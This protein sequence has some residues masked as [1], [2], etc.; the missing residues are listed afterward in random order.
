MYMPVGL[1]DEFGFFYLCDSEN[2]PEPVI[3]DV[4]TFR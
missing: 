2:N 1:I 3:G 4:E